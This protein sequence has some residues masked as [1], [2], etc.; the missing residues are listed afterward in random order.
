MCPSSGLNSVSPWEPSFFLQSLN[1]RPLLPSR[2]RA[3]LLG[4]ALAL[5]SRWSTELSLPLGCEFLEGVDGILI[6]TSSYSECGHF[7]SAASE[8]WVAGWLDG[9]TDGEDRW[10]GG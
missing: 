5:L 4:V 3:V 8:R 2:H 6:F 7:T 9:R 1:G 10:V